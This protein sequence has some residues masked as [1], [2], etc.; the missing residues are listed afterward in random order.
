[1]NRFLIVATVAAFAAGTWGADC[2]VEMA[3]TAPAAAEPAPTD[4]TLELKW[5]S[6]LASWR[7]CWITGRDMWVGNDFDISTISA[8]RVVQAIKLQSCLEWPNGRWDGFRI[9]VYNFSGSV[10]GS[11]LWGPTFV[12]PTGATGWKEFN[13]SWTLPSGVDMFLA[14]QEQY[15]D[16][17][18]C[19]PFS[20]DNNPNFLGHSWMGN[21]G[22]WYPL[23][24]PSYAPYRNLMVRVIVNN[25]TSALTPTSLGRV[26]A[27][28]R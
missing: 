9:G 24:L 22:T 1:M 7:V 13:V 28:F 6:G 27:L 16:Y 5:D 12:V 25:S 2:V 10:P 18:N 4:E 3:A 11:L 26:K 23:N 21:S 15:Y 8:Y 20:L 14:A 17:P 19:E